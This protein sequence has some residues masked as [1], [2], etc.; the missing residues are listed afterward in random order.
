VTHV[1]STVLLL[2]MLVPAGCAHDPER[3]AAVAAVEGLYGELAAH[4][5]SGA[6][7]TEELDALTPWLGEELERLLAKA[8]TVHDLERERAPGDKPPFNDGDLFSSLFE[9]PTA[10]DVG[11]ASADGR[12][13]RVP[14]AFTY[15][16]P[17]SSTD[18]TDTVIVAKE[19][20][21]WVVVDLIYGGDWDFAMR[22]SL[23]ANLR[24][25]LADYSAP[26]P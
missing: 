16:A 15:V 13:W 24:A 17:G 1:W 18:W 20:G 4:P 3:Q 10:F 21:G 23:A 19:A 12:T 11:P 6:P 8:R 7:S 26:T 2:A 25:G 5:V 9:G 22:G 14:V